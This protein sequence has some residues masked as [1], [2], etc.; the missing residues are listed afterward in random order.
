MTPQ[1]VKF[2]GDPPPKKKNIHKNLHTPKTI[3]IQNFGTQKNRPSM[4]YN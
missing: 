4:M 2:S 1:I 3:V